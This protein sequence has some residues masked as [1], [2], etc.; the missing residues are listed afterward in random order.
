MLHKTLRETTRAARLQ[1]RSSVPHCHSFVSS[2]L[3]LA[4]GAWVNDEGNYGL[5]WM[6]NR[7]HVLMSTSSTA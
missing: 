3:L 7:N 5:A 1:A 4:E 2:C 6:K